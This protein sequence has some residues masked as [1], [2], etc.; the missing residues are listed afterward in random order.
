M[1]EFNL[2]ARWVGFSERFPDRGN[3]VP[4]RD[5]TGYHKLELVWYRDLDWWVSGLRIQ[6]ST[7]TENWE[8]LELRPKENVFIVGDYAYVATMAIVDIE[9][10]ANPKIVGYTGPDGMPVDESIGRILKEPIKETPLPDEWR[11]KEKPEPVVPL[12]DG[13]HEVTL[14]DGRAA[15][16]SDSG[17]YYGPS[18]PL[19][20]GCKIEVSHCIQRIEL[21]DG[22]A[23]YG[24]EENNSEPV[25]PLPY[26]RTL[27]VLEALSESIRL[28]N[29]LND[30]LGADKECFQ[31]AFTIPDGSTSNEKHEM[32]SGKMIPSESAPAIPRDVEPSNLSE[33]FRLQYRLNKR[34]GADMIDIAAV[35]DKEAIAQWTQKLATAMQQELA[36]LVDCVPWKWW[37]PEEAQP[38]DRQNARVEIV[39]LFHFLISL[40]QLHCMSAEDVYNTYRAK[41]QINHKRQDS[42]YLKKDPDDCRGI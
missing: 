6:E 19:L 17:G 9:D 28:Q 8:W 34:I 31:Y 5:I 14:P 4:A 42:G 25:V 1:S 23:F 29:E 3:V 21:P 32:N 30:R 18:V 27:G 35:G 22:R 38:Y 41:C 33:M 15:L 37:R 39:D 16:V 10:R 13:I 24:F 7:L 36:E 2:E 26:G 20:D 12:P 40:A 11:A